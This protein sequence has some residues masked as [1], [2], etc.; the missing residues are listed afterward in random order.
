MSE[1]EQTI[2]QAEALR[3]HAELN[4]LQTSQAIIQRL[5]QILDSKLI[6]R[7]LVNAVLEHTRYRRALLLLMDERDAALSFGAIAPP[8]TSSEWMTALNDLFISTY[9]AEHDPMIRSWLQGQPVSIVGDHIRQ[10]SPMRWLAHILHTDH[11]YSVPLMQQGRVIGVLVLDAGDEAGSAEDEALLAALAPSLAMMLFNARIHSKTVD[12]LAAKMRQLYI[13]RQIDRELNDTIDLQHVFAMTL[14]WALRFTNGQAA[15]LALFDEKSGDLRYVA[16]VGYSQT[17]E[18]LAA[19][20][21]EHGLSPAH[22]TARAGRAEIIPDVSMDKDYLRLS[23]TVRSQL[24]APIMREDR[25]IAVITV[26]SK[27]LNAFA[28]E[29]L[30]FVEKLGARA[31]VAIDNGRLFAESVRERE[32]LARILNNTADVVIVVDMEGRL[33]LL[34]PSIIGVMRLDPEE[35]YIGQRY[36]DVFENTPLL[37]SFRQVVASEQATVAEIHLPNNR[38]FYAN[39]APYS[40]IGWIIVMHDITPLKET[41]RLKSELVATVSHDLKQPLSVMQG[42]T[43]LLQMVQDLDP[44]VSKYIHMIQRSVTNMRALID[45]VLDLARIE[46]GIQLNPK[47]IPIQTVIADCVEAVK[48]AADAKA[49]QIATDLPDSLPPVLGERGY[50]SQ[51]FLNL[52]SNAVK[53]TPARG[54]VRIWAERHG[55]T[56]RIAVQDTGV[57]ISPEDQ[58]HIFERFYRVRRP[59]TDNV[60]GTG[61][62]LAIVK[63]LIEVHN[64]QIGLVSRLGE[65]STFYIT[66]PIA[67]A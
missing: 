62:G 28:E 61:L 27:K 52:I 16:E 30:D 48:P 45:D 24:C 12:D 1:I 43:E 51:I 37:D 50:L 9:N 7:D 3:L 55:S 57:G 26:E 35:N 46:A 13:L 56:L 17:K 29:H 6:T 60:D 41:E 47:S 67:S 38:T 2:D 36:V 22:R 5:G 15:S 4:R 8:V 10:T 42:Y 63:R 53:Y 25:V 34:S 49:M 33:E 39:L 11:L 58:A 21:G 18:H 19:L 14:D 40:G 44:Q 59:E 66:L 23:N 64:G 54:S 32:K 31:G 20:R 65:G